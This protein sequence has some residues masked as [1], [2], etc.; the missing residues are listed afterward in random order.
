MIVVDAENRPVG[1]SGEAGARAAE[2]AEAGVDVLVVDT[3]HGHQARMTEALKECGRRS[4]AFRWRRATSLRP[5][6]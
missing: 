4:G 5:G 1:I 6:R 3:A 2:L